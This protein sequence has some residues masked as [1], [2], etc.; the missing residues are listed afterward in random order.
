MIGGIFDGHPWTQEAAEDVED[1]EN[2][3][4]EHLSPGFRVARGVLP[5][6]QLFARQRARTAHAQ[7]RHGGPQRGRREPHRRR[8]RARVDPQIR[9]GRVFYSAFGHFE[10]SFRRR[11]PHHAAAGAA[12]ADG[13]DRSGC[14]AALG[15]S[16]APPAIAATGVRNAAA[17][18]TLSR[19]RTSSRS[20][21][22]RLTSGR[23]FAAANAAARA[24]RRDACGSERHPAP[25]FSV[26][27]DRLLAQLPASL[28]PGQPASL[29]VSSANRPPPPW[30]CMSKLPIRE[31][32]RLMHRG[33]ARALSYGP[34]RYGPPCTKAS[35]RPDGDWPGRWCCRRR[36]WEDFGA[37]VRGTGRASWVCFRSTR[38]LKDAPPSFEIVVERGRTPGRT[39]V[40]VSSIL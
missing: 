16:A 27:P 12:V 7:Y 21:A 6:P 1:P 20:P 35:R 36:S 17:G 9:Q 2:P 37:V 34:G 29:A 30:L 25:L 33:R 10:D 8:F 39:S 13:R 23:H 19:R 24:A 26:R 4:V 5:V 14:D 15:P 18:G 32:R 28:V 40:P 3:I 31:P 22:T 38:P 11:L